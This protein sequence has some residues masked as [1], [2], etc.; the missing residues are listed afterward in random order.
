MHIRN[1]PNDPMHCIYSLS[2]AVVLQGAK[3]L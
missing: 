3:L 1:E 2:L